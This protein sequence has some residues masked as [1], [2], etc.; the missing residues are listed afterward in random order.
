[1]RVFICAF[2]GFSLAIPMSSIASLALNTREAA[3]AVEY[4]TEDSNTYISLPHLFSLSPEVISHSLVLK[5][6][7]DI[8]G[9]DMEN[10]SAI[11]NKVILLTTEVTCETEISGEDIFTVPKAFGSMRFSA[12]FNGIL[13]DTG[14]PVL[15]LN[16][17]TL[18]RNYKKERAA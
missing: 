7:E 5:N 9:N 17:E 11:T 16:T 15:I 12:L 14:K 3:Q 10:D 4:N 1:M 6:S 13:F 8:D 2:S 18:V